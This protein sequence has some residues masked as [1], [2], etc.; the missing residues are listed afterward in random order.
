MYQKPIGGLSIFRRHPHLIKL[1]I[2]VPSVW[3]LV[4]VLFAF[5]GHESSTRENAQDY[6]LNNIENGSENSEKDF[7]DIYETLKHETEVIFCYV[8]DTGA[9]GHWNSKKLSINLRFTSISQP[10]MNAHIFTKRE[11]SRKIG[12]RKIGER[13]IGEA[14]DRGA[15]DREGGRSGSGK[16]PIF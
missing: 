13:K 14:E 1:L 12:E 2:L 11:D 6:Q 16:S 3:L 8:F 7:L 9:N 5:S 15:E 10:A 4:L